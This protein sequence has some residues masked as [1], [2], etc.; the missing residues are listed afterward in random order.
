[1]TRPLD[2]DRPRVRVLVTGVGGRSVGAGIL[3]AL[4]RADNT[5]RRRWETVATDAD[6]FSWG[7]YVADRNA[8]VPLA[9][10]PGYLDRLRELI[11]AYDLAAVIPGT[12][13]EAALLAS[14]RDE[15]S[16]PVIAND[17]SLMCLMTDKKQAEAKLRELGLN[18]IPCYPWQKRDQAVSRFGFPLVIKPT[19][20]TGGSRGVH[21]VTNSTELENLCPFIRLECLP[22]VQPYLGDADSEYTVGVLSDKSGNVIDS[23]V[24]RRK[25]VGLSLLDSKDYA[26]RTATISTGI[27]QGFVV[28]HQ[29]IQEYCEDLAK[30]LS[31][32]GP[33][34][35]QLR[36]HDG[37]FY[38]FEIHP[39]FSGTTPIRASAGFNEPD[40]L[41]RNHLY[42][43]E[44]GRLS[45]RENLAAIR[46]FEHVLVPMGEM[47]W[48]PQCSSPS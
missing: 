17:A 45:Y 33:L 10:T 38:V 23:I 40:I 3:H 1:M 16:V 31:S 42:D 9:S 24:I 39:R 26:G 36:V 12:E 4:M 13:P 6:P 41:L 35:L 19:R 5:V 48:G 7:L 34:N 32:R 46:A 15:L 47:C 27:S 37:E 8:L 14:H 30:R 22:V 18:F 21:L 11:A 28:R 25:L 44:F 2:G 29:E 20:G 43:E